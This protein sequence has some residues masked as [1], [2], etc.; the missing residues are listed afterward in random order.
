MEHLLGPSADY[1][2]PGA[3]TAQVVFL[4]LTCASLPFSD[5]VLRGHADAILHPV[6]TLQS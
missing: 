5:R 2:T 3:G 4:P 6:I 1:G